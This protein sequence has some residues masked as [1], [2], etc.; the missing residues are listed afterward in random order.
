[1]FKN[2]LHPIEVLFSQIGWLK[3]PFAFPYGESQ[4]KTLMDEEL[5][6]EE[7]VIKTAALTMISAL[8]DFFKV[9]FDLF[10]D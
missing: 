5:K 6:T 10:D 2:Y 8:F 9:R 7:T 4:F 1:M 3:I